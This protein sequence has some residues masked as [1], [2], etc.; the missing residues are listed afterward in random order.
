MQSAEKETQKLI[1]EYLTRKGLFHYR[2]N[3]GAFKRGGRM[4][5]FGTPGAPDILVVKKGRYIG[6][7]V[8]GP[9][10]KQEP[11]Q[12]AFQEALEKAGGAYLL[13]RSVEEVVAFL[14]TV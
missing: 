1:L 12:V 14:K 10:E 13:A 3:T 8:K 5:K 7:E 2:Q 11:D 4:Y 9:T 6:I